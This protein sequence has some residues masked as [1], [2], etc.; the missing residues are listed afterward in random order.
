MEEP[1]ARALKGLQ[2]SAEPAALLGRR[3]GQGR[4]G[5]DWRGED[6]P[7]CSVLPE[8]PGHSFEIKL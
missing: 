5:G 7:C 3:P 2:L 4:V 1:G 6:R 8:T